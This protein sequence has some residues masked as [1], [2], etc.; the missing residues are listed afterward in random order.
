MAKDDA[1]NTPGEKRGHRTPAKQKEAET[2]A[3]N[4]AAAKAAGKVQGRIG[5]YQR[6]GSRGIV[7]TKSGPNRPR[8]VTDKS[9]KRP[10]GGRG[11]VPFN[12]KLWNRSILPAG[13][14]TDAFKRMMDRRSR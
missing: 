12:P 5:Q 7:A 6:A 3:R 13:G 8:P 9:P 11:G 1:S 2:R 10:R 4:K 14:P